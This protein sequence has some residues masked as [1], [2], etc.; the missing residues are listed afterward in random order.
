VSETIGDMQIA[1]LDVGDEPSPSSRRGVIER[2][3]IALLSNARKPPINRPSEAWLGWSCP[4][5]RVRSS[6][7]W[8]QN[9]VDEDYDPRFLDL[10]EHLVLRQEAIP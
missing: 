4:R 6:G 2:N 5:E 1:W 3:C 10:F 9:H 7:L 8:N